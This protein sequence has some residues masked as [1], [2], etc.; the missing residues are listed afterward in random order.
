MA[1]ETTRRDFLSTSLAVG[2]ALAI[3]V[4][5]NAAYAPAPSSEL[6]ELTIADIAA[7]LKSG[8]YTARS[9][10]QKY[11]QGIAEMDKSTINAVIET[12]PD[13]LAIADALDKEYKSKGARGPMHGVPVLIKDNID[14]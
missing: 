3:P 13:A 8:K 11:L 14:T 12:N 4:S 1:N 7:G 10:T 9:L 6:D 5:A 2:A